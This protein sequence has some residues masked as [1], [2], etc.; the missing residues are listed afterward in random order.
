MLQAAAADALQPTAEVVGILQ[1]WAGEVVACINEDD[2]RALA[3]KQA[4]SR[5]VRRPG[6]RRPRQVPQG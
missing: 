6:A 4:S 1:R 3:A 5:Q 2:E